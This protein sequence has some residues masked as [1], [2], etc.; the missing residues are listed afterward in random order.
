MSTRATALLV[1]LGCVWGAS[2]LFIKVIVEEASPLELV[3]GRLLLGSLT[4]SVVLAVRGVSIRRSPSRLAPIAALA[5]LSNIVPFALIAWAEKHVETGVAAVLNSTMPLFTALFAAAFLNEERFSPA[6]VAGLAAGFAGV[7]VLTG[8]DLL[9]VT[10]DHVLG[11]L[12]VIGGSACY[13]LGAVYGRTI[14][15]S[16]DPL[17]L[18]A[19]QLII[20]AMVAAPLAVGVEGTPELGLG[21][22]GWLSL[23]AL[24]V[25]ATGVAQLVYFWLLDQ[26]GSV[27]ASLVTYIIPIVALFLGWAVLDEGIGVN[28]V[29]GAALIIGGV[30]AVLRGQAP[31]TQREATAPAPAAD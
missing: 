15:R 20:G 13:G 30:A 2:F 7:A 25:I 29:L 18:T 26:A 5:V 23:L 11:E 6:S 17:S 31:G 14:L 28:T 19:L 24:G 12:A 9:D 27:R 3:A 16:E 10:S 21:V 1:A 8:G 4:V 22:K